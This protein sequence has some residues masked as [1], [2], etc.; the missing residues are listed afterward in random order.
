MWRVALAIIFIVAVLTICLVM[1]DGIF[2]STTSNNDA[3][4]IWQAIN[5]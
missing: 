4:G 5:R 3:V 1:A 2:I